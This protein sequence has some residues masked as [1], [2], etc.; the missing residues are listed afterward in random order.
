MFGGQIWQIRIQAVAIYPLL[1][2]CLTF[3]TL[4]NGDKEKKNVAQIRQQNNFTST[5]N[6]KTSSQIVCKF[7][8][9]K[10]VV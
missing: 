1:Q 7:K 3:I 9:L 2:S 5:E 4:R 6:L 10:N 8:A